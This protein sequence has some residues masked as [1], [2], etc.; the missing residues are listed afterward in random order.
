MPP[1]TAFTSFV[2]RGNCGGL[3][4]LLSSVL[5]RDWL[6]QPPLDCVMF[7]TSSPIVT[8]ILLFPP[9]PFFCVCQPLPTT[10]PSPLRTMFCRQ[11]STRVCPWLLIS[12]FFFWIVYVCVCRECVFGSCFTLHPLC[13]VL[14]NVCD[15]IN[16]ESWAGLVL[17]IAWILERNNGA[18]KRGHRGEHMVSVAIHR[19]PGM[20]KKKKNRVSVDSFRFACVAP[21]DVVLVPGV[22]ISCEWKLTS[23]SAETLG[24]QSVGAHVLGY[25]VDHTDAA[26]ARRAGKGWGRGY[27]DCKRTM[28]GAWEACFCTWPRALE[29][30]LL[31]VGFACS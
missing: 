27:V 3:A 31:R 26:Y 13:D 9:P 4:R 12:F 20:G 2:G 7:L 8:P 14:A 6:W 23:A 25:L 17:C 29:A 28:A 15:V 18:F 30:R 10:R 21:P 5:A 24:K 1:A 19:M 22:E 16:V 11:R